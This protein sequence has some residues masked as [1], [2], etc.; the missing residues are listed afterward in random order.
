MPLERILKLTESD[1]SPQVSEA[2]ALAYNAQLV[3]SVPPK[4][5]S[6]KRSTDLTKADL[7]LKALFLLH[8]RELSGGL[9]SCK[10]F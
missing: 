5:R 3:N 7:K 2:R 8:I 1:I 6:T 4:H 9:Y 10:R